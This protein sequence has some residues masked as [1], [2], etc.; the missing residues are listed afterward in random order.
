MMTTTGA[1]CRAAMAWAYRR[2][3]EM[4]AA[5]RRILDDSIPGA[6]RATAAPARMAKITRT[7]DISTKV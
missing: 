4:I 3:A 5:A 7:S 6:S 2:S 1:C